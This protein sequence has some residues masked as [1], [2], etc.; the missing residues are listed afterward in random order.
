M[1]KITF[2]KNY[3]IKQI[4]K[5]RFCICH[6]KDKKQ[7]SGP[8][9]YYVSVPSKNDSVILLCIITSKA[10]KI[11]E[12]YRITR[13]NSAIVSLIPIKKNTFNF[14]SDPDTVVECNRAEYFTI[15]ELELRISGIIEIKAFDKD[16]PEDLKKKIVQGI[17]DSSIV[18]PYL[19]SLLKK[20]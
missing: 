1:E 4:I 14:L 7:T 19:K 5:S 20:E 6:F 2:P 3:I 11:K 10:Q 18:S 13:R 9:H 8:S 12:H 17:K 16:F 15:E